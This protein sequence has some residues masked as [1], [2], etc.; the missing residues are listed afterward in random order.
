MH[1]CVARCGCC[2]GPKQGLR[3]VAEAGDVE[4]ALGKVRAYK[5]NVLVLDLCMPGGS[6]LAAIPTL[7]EASPSTAIVVLTMQ[8]G[9][10]FARQTLRSPALGFVRREAAGTELEEGVHAAVELSRETR[11]DTS[12]HRCARDSRL[13]APGI[14]AELRAA[15]ARLQLASRIAQHGSPKAPRTGDNSASSAQPGEPEDPVSARRG[16]R[17][18]RSRRVPSL[19]DQ[20]DWCL[21]VMSARCGLF[22]GWRRAWSNPTR[23]PAASKAAPTA[24]S[25]AAHSSPTPRSHGGTDARCA[26]NS[27]D[28]LRPAASHA[29]PQVPMRCLE[30]RANANG[31]LSWG[32]RRRRRAAAPPDRQS[33]VRRLQTPSPTRDRSPDG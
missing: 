2:S 33:R 18:P 24:R 23:S 9:P 30:I 1:W 13:V 6:S 20:T 10:A 11:R 17:H 28:P 7:L 8:G 19:S 5:P 14:Q 4:E 15:R 3:L 16:T 26:S 27:P 22:S 29:R 31:E 32:V 25:C 12:R 21:G